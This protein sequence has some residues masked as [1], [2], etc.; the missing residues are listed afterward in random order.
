VRFVDFGSF[1]RVAYGSS[2]LFDWEKAPSSN[3]WAEFAA[4]FR[5]TRSGFP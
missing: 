2:F 5:L 3:S 4:V 1:S